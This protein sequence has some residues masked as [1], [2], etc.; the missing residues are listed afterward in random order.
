MLLSDLYDQYKNYDDPFQAYKDIINNDGLSRD[1]AYTVL[2]LLLHRDE[3]DDWVQYVE[4]Y[5]K[6]PTNK[7]NY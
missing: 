2:D 7:Y 6:L 1:V 5:D 4:T 3:Y